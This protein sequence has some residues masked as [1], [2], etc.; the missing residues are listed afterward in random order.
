MI[1]PL[2]HN[3]EDIG[4]PVLY[5][6]GFSFLRYHPQFLSQIAKDYD[7]LAVVV[8]GAAIANSSLIIFFKITN[9]LGLLI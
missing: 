9:Y 2:Y 7:R 5:L 3:S 4:F 6:G 1:V 8:V